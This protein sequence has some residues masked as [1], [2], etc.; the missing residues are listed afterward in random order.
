MSK[1]ASFGK[2]RRASELNQRSR[3]YVESRARDWAVVV[4]LGID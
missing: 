3:K 4:G 1:S 2:A